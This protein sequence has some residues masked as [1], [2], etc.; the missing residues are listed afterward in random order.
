MELAKALS[1]KSQNTYF[2]LA[3]HLWPGEFQEICG[4][5]PWRVQL[6]EGFRPAPMVYHRVHPLK[7]LLYSW[8]L[9]NSRTLGVT[10][11][12][13]RV[14]LPPLLGELSATLR[15][16]VRGARPKPCTPWYKEPQHPLQEQRV[17]TST[18]LPTHA[19]ADR[20]NSQ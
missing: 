11:P 1:P 12:A 19:A 2:N 9:Y 7:L 18:L 17:K 15:G 5:C 6:G 10:P 4:L 16:T 13:Q 3:C 20:R 8:E 14:S